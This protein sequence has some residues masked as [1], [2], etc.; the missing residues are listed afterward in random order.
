MSTQTWSLMEAKADVN[1]MISS[2]ISQPLVVQSCIQMQ[3]KS[4]HSPDALYFLGASQGRFFSLRAP[5]MGEDENAHGKQNNAVWRLALTWA[6]LPTERPP[7]MRGEV[8]VGQTEKQGRPFPSCDNLITNELAEHLLLW[9]MKVSHHRTQTSHIRERSR[10][11]S[12]S[13]PHPNIS[14]QGTVQVWKSLTT[15]PKHLISGNGLGG[16]C[17]ALDVECLWW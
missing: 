9:H 17:D 6:H 3:I 15:A 13:P 16:Q 2:H 8:C 5:E 12:L 4:L 10:F 7:K 11:E 14:Y 1:V